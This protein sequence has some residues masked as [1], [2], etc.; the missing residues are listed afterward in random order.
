[1]LGTAHAGHDAEFTV[2][3]VDRLSGRAADRLAHLVSEPAGDAVGGGAGF[4]AGPQGGPRPLLVE[5]EK[6][7]RVR[8]IGL[9][10]DLFARA[11]ERQVAGR[12]YYWNGN[13]SLRG[14]VSGNCVRGY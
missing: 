7:E 13:G 5:I 12:R 9:P 10:A 14:P 11:S 6:L 8:A 1:M 3:T 2:R 4:L